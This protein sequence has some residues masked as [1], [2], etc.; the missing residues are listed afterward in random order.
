MSQL[1]SR[2]CT[3]TSLPIM[4]AILTFVERNTHLF[5]QDPAATQG[6]AADISHI[7]LVDLPSIP[8]WPEVAP[9]VVP[10][11]RA[12]AANL[13]LS[14]TLAAKLPPAQSASATI[15]AGRMYDFGTTIVLETYRILE[16]DPTKVQLFYTEF[17]KARGVL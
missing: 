15:L 8:A 10:L 14:G 2:H 6:A 4:T 12:F 16:P 11:L 7:L 9:S 5:T 17:L 3:A 1:L 13:R